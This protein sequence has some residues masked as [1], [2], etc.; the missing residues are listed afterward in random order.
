M[1]FP[2][3]GLLRTY[4]ILAHFD[5]IGGYLREFEKEVCDPKVPGW[6]TFLNPQKHT[7]DAPPKRRDFVSRTGII[8][9]A[10]LLLATFGIGWAGSKLPAKVP[11][12]AA[13]TVTCK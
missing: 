12:S 7:K 11:P 1:A 6:E 5:L 13:V 10:V 2:I 3:F 4:A 8:F 9:W